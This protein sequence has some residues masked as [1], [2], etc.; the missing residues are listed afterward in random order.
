MRSR[1]MPKKE[2]EN[3]SDSWKSLMNLFFL[4]NGRSKQ[5][6][7]ILKSLY[8]ATPTVIFLRGGLCL[9]GNDQEFRIAFYTCSR[10]WGE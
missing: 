3:R 5:L 8:K 1:F 9:T 6:S 10:P 2:H 7:V 4:E